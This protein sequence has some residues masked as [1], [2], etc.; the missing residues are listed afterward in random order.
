MAKRRSDDSYIVMM[1]RALPPR[2]A[3]VLFSSLYTWRD[4]QE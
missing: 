4:P 1:Y 3:C 2:G